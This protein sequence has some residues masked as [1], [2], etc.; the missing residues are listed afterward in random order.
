MNSRDWD[1]R[2]TA[3][4]L[5]WGAEPNRW[6]VREL[7]GLTPGRALDLAAG[8]GRNSIWLARQGW[9]VTGLDFSAAGLRRAA[10]LTAGLPAEVAARLTWRQDDARTFPAPPE[11]GRAHL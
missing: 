5:V 2:Y 7:A 3:S 11:N 9:R 8:E 10:R 6:V 4:E 1:E